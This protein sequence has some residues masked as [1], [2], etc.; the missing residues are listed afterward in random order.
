MNNSL[1]DVHGIEL[2]HYTDETNI[3]GCSVIL[4]R[5]GAIAGVDQRGGAPGSRELA[6]LNPVNQVDKVH[7]VLLSGGS[8]YGLDAAGGVMRYLEENNI[9]VNVGNAR[10]PIVPA[11]II[12]DLGI[13]NPN[14][15]PTPENAY[16]ACLDATKVAKEQGSI[17][18]GTGAT[19]GKLLGMGQ[20]VKAGLGMAS[21]EIG[22]GVIVSALIVVNAVGEIFNPATNQIIAGTR[23]P[24]IAKKLLKKN[25]IFVDSLAL[26]QGPIG[27]TIFDLA[28]PSNTVIGVVAT[29]AALTKTQATKVAQMAQNGLAR[30]IR[31]ANTM[32][33]GDTIYALSTGKKKINMNII[34]T[35]AAEMVAHAIL[36][37]IHH[38]KS[39]GGVPSL[40]EINQGLA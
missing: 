35:F 28:A 34:G 14:I 9:G 3:T 16:Q 20:A 19:I 29:N 1:T 33:D 4:C 8:A 18:A 17:G 11:S 23:N 21:I 39:M 22:K 13:G 25:D 6:L 31:P 37:A 26:M 36:N 30:T 2:G 24:D 10:V 32:L 40:A 12:L 27:R 5:D 7:A 38:A 15:R